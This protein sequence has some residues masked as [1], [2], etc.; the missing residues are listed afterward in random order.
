MAERRSASEP[1][2]QY[3]Y[4]LDLARRYFPAHGRLLDV[5]CGSGDWAASI[6]RELPGLEAHGVDVVAGCTAN[7]IF[8]QYDGRLLPFSDGHFDAVL[9]FSVLHHAEVPEDLV[10]E[11][12]R[13]SRL[14]ARI[15]V[16]EDIVSSRVQKVLT[17]IA[18][19]YAN[20]VRNVGRAL[21]GTG[22]WAMARVPMTYQYRSYPEWV[23]VFDER[24]LAV[25]QV[26]SIPKL[27]V[28]HGV[29]VLEKR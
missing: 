15:L 24:G 4:R 1:A 3:K 11:I 5:G 18:D 9:V 28:E 21:R 29:F 19:V 20:R 6:A 22:R 17:R 27:M 8:R 7:I 25:L 12:S 16:V 23:S 14:G 2:P 10:S 26:S 13:V